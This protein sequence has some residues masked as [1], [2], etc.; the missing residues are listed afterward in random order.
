MKS[1]FMALIHKG[2][3]AR[4]GEAV[5]SRPRVY[6]HIK[7]LIHYR[8]QLDISSLNVEPGT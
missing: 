8:P 7:C 3:A 5:A 6:S 2:V 1:V 4:I